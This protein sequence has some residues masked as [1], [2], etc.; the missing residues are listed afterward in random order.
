MGLPWKNWPPFNCC[1][2]EKLNS[3][4][5]LKVTRHCTPKTVFLFGMILKQWSIWRKLLKHA[6]NTQQLNFMLAC[7][8][9]TKDNEF[10]WAT[11]QQIAVIDNCY[12]WS[13]NSHHRS[14]S[15]AQLSHERNKRDLT[16]KF[17]QV[18]SQ[19]RPDLI[20]KGFVT[21]FYIRANDRVGYEC[22]KILTQVYLNPNTESFRLLCISDWSGVLCE[23]QPFHRRTCDSCEFSHCLDRVL[24]QHRR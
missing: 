12:Q 10:I 21:H 20:W 11:G 4:C 15:S 17:K 14:L 3:S 2:A 5:N 24:G 8:K 9:E 19:L 23:I 1:N 16:A 6:H 7:I 22:K 18:V 13:S